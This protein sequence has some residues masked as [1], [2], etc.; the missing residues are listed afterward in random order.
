MTVGRHPGDRGVGSTRWLT[1]ATG[2]AV[3]DDEQSSA[4]L[5]QGII[6]ST[7][8]DIPA[9]CAA[10][11]TVIDLRHR[12]L[13]PMANVNLGVLLA[14]LDD[15]AGAYAAFRRAIASG[16]PDQAPRA[17]VHLGMLL[18]DHGDTAGSRAAYQLA[19]AL[20]C[21]NQRPESHAA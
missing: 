1:L 7:Q 12:D 3:V 4:A 15:R 21:G 8:G 6:L 2:S 5:L 20:A 9:A 10:Y 18:A 13:A 14:V 11:R 19:I 17:A 16:H